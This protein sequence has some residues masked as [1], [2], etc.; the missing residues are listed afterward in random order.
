MI[1]GSTMLEPYVP[2]RSFRSRLRDQSVDGRPF[3][4]YQRF[5]GLPAMEWF[6]N[7]AT[8]PTGYRFHKREPR[9]SKSPHSVKS[10]PVPAVVNTRSTARWFV[11]EMEGDLC[12]E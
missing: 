3:C 2:S 8:R 12:S 10:R 11:H 9:F 1:G 4:K 5:L 7:A 6:A